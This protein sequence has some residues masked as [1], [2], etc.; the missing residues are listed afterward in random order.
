MTEWNNRR[1]R[2]NHDLLRNQLIQSLL[3]FRRVCDGFIGGEGIVDECRSQVERAL[4]MVVDEA[5]E[6]LATASKYCG[7]N[8]W[9]E[10]PP[11][12]MLPA[13]DRTWM[14]A[15]LQDEW[16]AFRG[17]NTNLEGTQSLLSEIRNRRKS[18]RDTAAAQNARM[19]GQ[20]PGKES[21][22][23]EAVAGLYEKCRSFSSMLTALN[24][25]DALNTF[26]RMDQKR[27]SEA[28]S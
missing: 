5:G 27:N 14:L 6:V 12:N 2:L 10:R 24:Y 1:S 4:S 7:P 15:V 21:D 17:F 11:L 23:A 28:N 3:R 8:E 20:P 13:E 25:G 22:L 16:A 26:A 19:S 18:L 9:F